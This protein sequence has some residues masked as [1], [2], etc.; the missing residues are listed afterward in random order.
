VSA[1][2]TLFQRPTSKTLDGVFYAV[3]GLMDTLD[4][5][6]QAEQ[7]EDEVDLS[8][9][10]AAIAAANGQIADLIAALNE[11]DL[12]GA[13][14]AQQEFELALVTQVD[15]ILGSV[16]QAVKDSIRRSEDS[17][18]AVIRSLLEGRKNAVNIKV[19]QTARVDEREAFVQQ[20]SEFSAQIG[21]SLGLV[22]Q[23]IVAR[24]DGDSANAEAIQTV[25]T[26]LDGN[27]A[28]VQTIQ[29]SV[30]GLSAKFGV[31]INLNGE[32]IGLVQLDGTPAGSNF[33]VL[34][35]NF[36][37]GKTG[38]S[39][40]DPVPV[41]AIR[42][43]DGVSKIG[44][45]A[46]VYADGDI[47]ARHVAAGAITAVKIAAG[48]ITTDKLFAGAVD[49]TALATG[50][51]TTAKIASSAVTSTELA[52][53][54]VTTAKIASSAVTAA[55]IASNAVT[56]AKILDA[57]IVTDKLG[58]LAVTADKIAANAVTAA[59]ID[60]GAVTTAKLDAGAV[61]AAKIAAGTI[62]A[63]KIAATGTLTAWRFESP[64][65]KAIFDFSN[66][67]KE[68]RIEN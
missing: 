50:A 64:D 4:R 23:E 19:E 55:E 14:T 7:D 32:V 53:S 10:N 16:S 30:N 58:A 35:D 57:S 25:S 20:V 18:A 43:I 27:V 33:T 46:D 42:T 37:V 1:R 6:R 68:I 36:V 62:T 47:V 11:I 24:A 2:Q 12:N 31:V 41:F 39:G 40:G 65:G 66:A 51:V 29:E 60:A 48:A 52:S 38:T 15:T 54:A 9:I 67:N 34:A 61:T 21:L 8:A 17:A 63:D 26:V 49:A 45:R 22:N 3:S 59:K 5:L 28:Q 56:T 44:L 13:L